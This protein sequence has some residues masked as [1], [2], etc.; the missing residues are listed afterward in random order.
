MTCIQEDH[1]CF[2]MFKV[3]IRTVIT[4]IDGPYFNHM[5]L[6][7]R[8][9]ITFEYFL[10]CILL[11]KKNHILILKQDIFINRNLQKNLFNLCSLDCNVSGYTKVN[12][13]SLR[14]LLVSEGGWHF[15]VSSTILSC[16][17]LCSL[18]YAY[19]YCS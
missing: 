12:T 4:G 18:L 6:K 7:Y 14:L 16:I 5:Y 11:N 8:F 17:I 9:L 1:S 19:I 3:K 13:L 15:S 10:I 2:L